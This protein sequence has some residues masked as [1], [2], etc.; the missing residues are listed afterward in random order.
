MVGVI[1]IILGAALLVAEAL[2]PGFGIFGI[3]GAISLLLGFMMLGEEPWVEMLGIVI[4]GLAVGI[5]IVLLILV[6]VVRGTKKK[7]IKVGKEE[8]IG[9]EGV[10]VKT[11]SPKGLVKLRGELWTASSSEKIKPGEKVVV[12]DIRGL[13]LIVERRD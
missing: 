1:F 5:V 8:L 2:T 7:P 12:K 4:K 13:E 3:G 10:V 9:A 11:I 6:A